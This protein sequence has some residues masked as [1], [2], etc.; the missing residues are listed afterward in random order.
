MGK[1]RVECNFGSR[2]FTDIGKLNRYLKMCSEKR[3]DFELWQVGYVY[4]VKE[5][6]Y[7]SAQILIYCTK[8]LHK[9]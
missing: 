5:K 1:Y 8:R 4:L 9:H 2:Y 6:R 3:L 7:V